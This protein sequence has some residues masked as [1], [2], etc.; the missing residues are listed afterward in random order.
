MAI[1]QELPPLVRQ[2]IEAFIEE[3]ETEDIDIYELYEKLLNYYERPFNLNS[4]DYETLKDLRLLTDIQ[5]QDLAYH[6]ETQG[7]LIAFEEL[8]S[9][10]SFDL[11]TVRRLK[12]FVRVSGEQNYNVPIGEMISKGRNELYLKW[13][14]ITEEQFGYQGEIFKECNDDDPL[15]TRRYIG[16][17]NRLFV[18]YKYSYENRFR[19]GFTMEKDSGEDFFSGSNPQGFDFMSA[20]VYAKELNR[21]IKDVVFGDYTIS[22]GQGLIMQNAFGSGKSAWVTDIKRG[23][24]MIKPYN[25]VNENL[26]LRGGA[27]SL[28]PLNSIELTVFGSRVNRDGNV[29]EMDTTD[30][31]DPEQRFS[32]IQTS[33]YHRTG[34]EIED[35]GAIQLTTMGASLKYKK[36]N[37]HITGNFLNQRFSNRFERNDNLNNLFRFQGE[38]LSNAS[39]DYS[40]RYRN[41]HF[42]GE[43]AMSLNNQGLANLHGLLMGLSKKASLAVLYRNYNRDYNVL[44]PNAFGESS[45]NRNERGVY[46]GIELNPSIHWKVRLYADMWKNPWVSSRIEKPST[47]KEYLLR[48]DYTQK[49]KF[50]IYA[51]F[52]YE[53]K[54]QNYSQEDLDNFFDEQRNTIAGF[55]H[56][57]RL[58][59][60]LNNQLSKS[61]ELRSRIEYSRFDQQPNSFDGIMLFQDVIY[62]PIASKFS[63]SGRYAIFDIEDTDARIYSYENDILYEFL[64]P[65]FGKGRG[66]RYYINMR[67]DLNRMFT[68]EFRFARTYFLDAAG[69]SSGNEL[70]IGDTRTELKAQIRIKF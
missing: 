62:R 16:D 24:R 66:T 20:Y 42:F 8:Q 7:K 3:Q 28:R 17:P 59:I 65:A 35:E 37:L 34:C 41:L 25:S 56:R 32:S 63:F 43:T 48:I 70:I 29:V 15:A 52:F 23:G 47:G 39:I 12:P 40:Y 57:Y 1:C 36:R 19:Y 38:Q 54:E 50:N 21:W 10:E 13:R 31:Q 51:Q 68:A 44:E 18:K 14:R 53:R 9:I 30:N 6:I 61:L 26:F 60:H 46:L 67:Y 49:R 22:M 45:S 58:R 5:I 64:I 55:T 11:E 27:V 2:Q 69:I 33:G 4:E